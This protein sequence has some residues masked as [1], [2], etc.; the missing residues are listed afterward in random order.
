MSENCNNDSNCNCTKVKYSNEEIIKLLNEVDELAEKFRKNMELPEPSKLYNIDGDQEVDVIYPLINTAKNGEKLNI[1]RQFSTGATRDTDINK[2]GY[3][4]FLSPIVLKAFAEYM[5][6]N[7]VMADGS[8]R[9]PDNW[10][11]LFGE[12]HEDVCMDSLLRHIMDVW[13]INRDF[14][15]ES[16]E[17]IKT[18]LCAIMFNAQAYLF[19]ILKDEYDNRKD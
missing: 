12:H 1:I 14:S 19:K 13:L 2:L 4:G 15:K 7:R 3:S 16:R 11:K 6:K 18:A 8:I 5:N 17:D 9:Q 10:Q